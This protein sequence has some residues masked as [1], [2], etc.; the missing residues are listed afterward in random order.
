MTGS[1][2]DWCDFEDAILCFFATKLLNPVN[3]I[4]NVITTGFVS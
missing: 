3:K 2:N 1:F 4:A